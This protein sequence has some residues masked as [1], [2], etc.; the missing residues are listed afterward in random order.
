MKPLS[1]GR[2]GLLAQPSRVRRQGRNGAALLEVVPIVGGQVAF[3]L[4]G[5]SIGVVSLQRLAN[6]FT[7]SGICARYGRCND[8]GD[9]GVL[10]VEMIIKAALRESG[11]AHELIEA[12]AVDAAFTKYAFRG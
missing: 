1:I 2:L 9:Q 5:E 4:P 3:Y 6:L 12:D 10:R 7:E 11:L 8:L